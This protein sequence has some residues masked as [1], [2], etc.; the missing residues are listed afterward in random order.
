MA[1]LDQAREVLEGIQVQGVNESILWSVDT[2]PWGGTPTSPSHDIFDIEDMSTSLKATLMPGTPS[3]SGDNVV[4][5]ALSG[6]S[7]DV[8]YIVTVRFATGGNTLEGYFRVRGQ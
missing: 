3:V 6:I 4:L 5:P 8:T 1:I 7:T 2:S